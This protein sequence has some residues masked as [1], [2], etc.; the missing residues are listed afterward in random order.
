MAVLPADACPLAEAADV[1]RY[2]QA[3][4]AGQCGPCVHG[5][6][7][8]ARGL[9][10]MAYRPVRGPRADHLLELCTLVEGRGACRHPDGV[11]R[12]VRTTLA[13]FGDELAL[14]G[15]GAP[16]SRVESPRVLP[17]APGIRRVSRA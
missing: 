3:Q 9:E 16:C 15:R 14:H 8:L 4:G 13:V 1:V 5:L 11:A 12:F 6:S 2:M 17:T 7:E 10:R